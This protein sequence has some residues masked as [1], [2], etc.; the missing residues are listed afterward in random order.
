M[1]RLLI[2]ST[3]NFT[4]FDNRSMWTLPMNILDAVL[5]DALFADLSGDFAA[6]GFVAG[7]VDVL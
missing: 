7:A 5:G 2:V 3:A 6:R 1:S 4:C